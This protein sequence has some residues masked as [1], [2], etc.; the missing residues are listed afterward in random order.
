MWV[1]IYSVWVAPK[2]PV[3]NNFKL[4]PFARWMHAFEGATLL[5]G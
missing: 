5:V 1:N 4:I 2:T 3:S